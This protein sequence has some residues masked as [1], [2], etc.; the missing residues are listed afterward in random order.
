MQQSNAGRAIS[1]AAVGVVSSYGTAHE[2][3]PNSAAD[4]CSTSAC[5]RLVAQLAQRQFEVLGTVLRIAAGATVPLSRCRGA[6]SGR[7]QGSP[8]CRSGR[9]RHRRHLRAALF[10]RS[11]TQLEQRTLH[12]LASR[13]SSRSTRRRA[14]TTGRSKGANASP[15]SPLLSAAVTSLLM[16]RDGPPP[17]LAAEQQ[18]V[19]LPLDHEPAARITAGS[20]HE[21]RG[22]EPADAL[23]AAPPLGGGRTSLPPVACC[24]SAGRLRTLC[25]SSSCCADL[26]PNDDAPIKQR[27]PV[28]QR[29]VLCPM[30][31]VEGHRGRVALADLVSRAPGHRRQ[32]VAEGAVRLR[33]L[34]R[35]CGLPLVPLLP[36]AMFI[37]ERHRR[38]RWPMADRRSADRRRRRRRCG[39]R[40]P[41]QP[42]RRR[43]PR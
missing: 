42:H 23:E 20:R 25:S 5:A 28:E 40:D 8:R 14:P 3:V 1:C 11:F 9:D 18:G 16:S 33:C 31:K 15:S 29:D 30:L 43:A 4:H 10:T 36:W 41:Q 17:T 38:R 19:V 35:D 37:S 13:C 26:E 34:I 7:T 12:L 32:T 27:T 6:S 2:T 39:V 22:A 21:D 24:W